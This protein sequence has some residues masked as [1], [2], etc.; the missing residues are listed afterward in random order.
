MITRQDLKHL[1]S[2]N[3]VLALSI[4]L[5]THRTSPDNEQDPILVKNLVSEAKTR[6][7]EEYSPGKLDPP[8]FC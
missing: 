8:H 2:L 5:T 3:P 4:L 7:R 6:P 1:Q